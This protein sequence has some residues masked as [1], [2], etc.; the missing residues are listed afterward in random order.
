MAVNRVTTTG[1]IVLLLIGVSSAAI[2][3]VTVAPA[4]ISGSV[5]W[6]VSNSSVTVLREFT[7]TCQV[8]FSY[9]SDQPVS[10]WLS[11][12]ASAQGLVVLPDGRPC[13][14]ELSCF[15]SKAVDP[16]RRYFLLAETL[17]QTDAYVSLNSSAAVA[18]EA[19]KPRSLIGSWPLV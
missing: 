16:T 15:A 5:N 14:N 17:Y 18:S 4:S 19:G 10:V 3:N 6:I 12:E 2:D 8:E 1:L 7:E 9:V 13:V 11:V